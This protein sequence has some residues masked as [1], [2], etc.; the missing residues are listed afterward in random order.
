MR[1][2]PRAPTDDENVN[3]S[4]VHPVREAV[5]LALGLL[6]AGMVGLAVLTFT[7][8]VVT[9]YIPP[10][11]EVATFGRAFDVEV[12][13][14]AAEDGRLAA[15]QAVLDPLLALDPELGYA[16]RLGILDEPQ[17]NAFAML[18]GGLFVTSGLLAQVESENELAFVLAHELASLRGAPPA[19]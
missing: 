11:V 19:Q 7:T 2:V 17:P 10:L 16:V 3:V 18:G 4:K 8:D 15:V 9:G 14:A 12:D 1:F 13:K 6:V 5:V